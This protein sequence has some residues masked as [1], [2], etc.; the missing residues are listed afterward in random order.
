MGWIGWPAL[1]IGTDGC[2]GLCVPAGSDGPEDGPTSQVEEDTV[3]AVI[4]VSIKRHL[5]SAPT[6]FFS[7]PL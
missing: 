6:G 7:F 2:G 3:T 5:T 1:D 4:S